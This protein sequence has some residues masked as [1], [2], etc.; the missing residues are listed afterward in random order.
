[1]LTLR[2]RAPD[3]SYFNDGDRAA[4]IF[5]VLATMFA[6][7]LGFV[8]FLSFT[9]YDAA[10]AGA[11]GEALAVSQMFETAQLLPA[12]A[13]DELSGELT[14][15]ARSV[16]HMEWPSMESGSD[17]DSINPWAV[18]LFRTFEAIEP[19]SQSEQAAFDEWLAQSDERYE[20]RADRL[21]TAD[22]VIP[23]PVWIVLFFSAALVLVYTV[24]F[25]DSGEPAF[26]QGLMMGSIAAVIV[27]SLLTLWVL[28]HPYS[29]H[30]GGVRP[31]AMERSLAEM[32]ESR[33]ALGMTGSIPCEE[34][35]RPAASS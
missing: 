7:M 35:G 25:A 31:I 29:K 16:V 5:G 6:L 18:E 11:R 19:V 27:M 34:S 22:G 28:D 10:R 32:Q 21:H 2:R 24:F 15:Y 12:D 30:P 33:E 13:S 9:R 20:A 26:I 4:G 1:M 8:V 14:C 3:G 17:V 23:T